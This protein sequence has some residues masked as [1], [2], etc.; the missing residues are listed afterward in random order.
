MVRSHYLSFFWRIIVEQS[1]WIS[2]LYINF[3]DFEKS[4]PIA[5]GD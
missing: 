4:V 5:V 1:E 2:S 3:I